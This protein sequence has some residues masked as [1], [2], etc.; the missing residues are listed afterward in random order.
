MLRMLA[1]MVAYKKHPKATA[2]LLHPRKAL[3]WGAM[4]WLGKKLLGS[5]KKQGTERPPR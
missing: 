4:F 2:A 3:K 5:D 1:K